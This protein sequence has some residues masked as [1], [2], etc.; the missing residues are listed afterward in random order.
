[1]S[2]VQIA[3]CFKQVSSVLE[4]LPPLLTLGLKFRCEGV[5]CLGWRAPVDVS[6]SS[7]RSASRLMAD[8]GLENTGSNWILFMGGVRK[9]EKK[10]SCNLERVHGGPCSG[11]FS[12][13]GNSRDIVEGLQRV[14]LGLQRGQFEKL[15][16][17]RSHRLGGHD[18]H[19]AGLVMSD[20]LH[21]NQ[22]R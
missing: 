19:Q 2:K 11:S 20:H 4:Q 10:G 7:L 9:M 5:R 21:T 18:G 22:Q 16:I 8:Y 15:P 13:R 1:M 12:E 3:C 17:L 6:F 14:T